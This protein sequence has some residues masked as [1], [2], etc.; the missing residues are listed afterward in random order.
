[1]KQQ[2]IT[3]DWYSGR[4][5]ECSHLKL[6]SIFTYKVIDLSKNEGT[7]FQFICFHKTLFMKHVE[8]FK[9]KY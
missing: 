3:N 2:R 6:F 4:D 5:C 1:M 9:A 7:L 8:H